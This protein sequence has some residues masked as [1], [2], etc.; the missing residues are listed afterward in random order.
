MALPRSRNVLR[1][2]E[3]SELNPNKIQ[4]AEPEK[5]VIERIYRRNF[6]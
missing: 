1:K 3:T 2:A 5:E 6:P 4:Q